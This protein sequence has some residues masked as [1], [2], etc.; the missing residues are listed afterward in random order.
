MNPSK[1]RI[2]HKG[3]TLNGPATL[4]APVVDEEFED[5]SL[6]LPAG[7]CLIK[8]KSSRLFRPRQQSLPSVKVHYYPLM[9]DVDYRQGKEVTSKRIK[10][11]SIADLIRV[12]RDQLY[13]WS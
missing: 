6:E 9:V 11:R 4:V 2:L 13:E 12:T 10:C 7:W 1:V 3:T 5:A 8:S